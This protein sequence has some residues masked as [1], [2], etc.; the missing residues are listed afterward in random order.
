MEIKRQTT[1]DVRSLLNAG[2]A[3]AAEKV[4]NGLAEDVAEHAKNIADVL[5]TADAARLAYIEARIDEARA[6]AARG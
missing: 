3:S 2:S 5:E 1:S 4:E 6:A